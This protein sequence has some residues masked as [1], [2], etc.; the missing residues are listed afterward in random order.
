[1]T[2]EHRFPSSSKVDAAIDLNIIPAIH[3]VARLTEV[4]MT[5]RNSFYISESQT[6]RSYTVV[7]N[8][9]FLYYHD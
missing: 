9:V 6:S 1:M 4:Y 8:V 2:F 3:P 7:V 5:Y